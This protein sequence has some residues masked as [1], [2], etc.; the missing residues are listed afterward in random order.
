MSGIVEKICI[1]EIW[2]NP[3]SVRIIQAMGLKE[4][5][6]RTRRVTCIDGLI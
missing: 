6:D 5:D 4:G 2:E 1:A 3:E